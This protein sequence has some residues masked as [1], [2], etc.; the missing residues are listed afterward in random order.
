[1]QER[2]TECSTHINTH[3]RMQMLTKT[4]VL[5]N[6]TTKVWHSATVWGLFFFFGPLKWSNK[7][8]KSLAKSRLR[9]RN[10][11]RERW[12]KRKWDQ[13]RIMCEHVSLRVPVFG[14]KRHKRVSRSRD[15]TAQW[16]CRCAPAHWRR[17]EGE[18]ERKKGWWSKVR[19]KRK[20]RDKN[21]CM[22]VQCIFAPECKAYSIHT[23]THYWAKSIWTLKHLHVIILKNKNMKVCH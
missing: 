16:L 12:W 15:F 22:Q 3:T 9:E 7:H 1:M 19:G 10:M 21:I 11:R 23:H 6:E 14:W 8:H 4:S 18:N 2:H 5:P 17:W 20:S 13:N